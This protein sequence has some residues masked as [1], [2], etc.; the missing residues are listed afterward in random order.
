[1]SHNAA[2]EALKLYYEKSPDQPSTA[3]DLSS[4]VTTQPHN[5]NGHR[6]SIQ[7]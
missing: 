6:A 2:Y 1:M 3:T 7:Q 5:G 4:L